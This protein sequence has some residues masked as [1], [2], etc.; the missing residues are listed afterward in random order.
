MYKNLAKAAPML[1]T[2]IK[3]AAAGGLVLLAVAIEPGQGKLC[4]MI[5]TAPPYGDRDALP[6]PALR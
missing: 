2:E 6:S 1:R 4:Q 3:H 5:Y